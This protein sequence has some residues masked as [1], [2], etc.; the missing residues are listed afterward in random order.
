VPNALQEGETEEIKN[1]FRKRLTYSG[2]LYY[3]NCKDKT[4]AQRTKTMTTASPARELKK[5]LKKEFPGIKFTVNTTRY[6]VDVRWE[7][8]LK[9]EATVAKV[10]AITSKYDTVQISGSTVYFNVRYEG[11]GINLYPTYT[12]ER[13][14]WAMNLT[15]A[16][17]SEMVWNG[18]RG[19]FDNFLGKEDR[20]T[21]RQ[22]Y[23][24][25]KNG[26]ELKVESTVTDTDEAKTPDKTESTSVSVEST[27]E[28]N[29]VQFSTFKKA[30]PAPTPQQNP[31]DVFFSEIYQ[32]WVKKLINNGE[33]NKIK[34]FEDWYAIAIQAL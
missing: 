20:A 34:S 26:V 28:S 8:E 6:S 7:I 23:E 31:D 15:K 17:N 30:T 3:I 1:I 5:A 22:Y 4:Q 18:A 21:T 10:D 9:T 11:Y 33:F 29:L 13:E 2:Y 32:A 19:T 16:N 14:E 24:Y 25:L 12:K 27:T